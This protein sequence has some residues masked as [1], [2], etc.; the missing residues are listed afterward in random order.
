MFTYQ[1][2]LLI[3]SNLEDKDLDNFLS[4]DPSIQ[5]KVVKV[6]S[7]AREASAKTSAE[8]QNT[9]SEIKKIKKVR[10]R[11]IDKPT[12]KTCKSKKAGT[13]GYSVNVS[14]ETEEYLKVNSVVSPNDIVGYISATYEIPESRKLYGSVEN[15][16]RR[17]QKSGK[18]VKI[19]RG[20]F[21]WKKEETKPYYNMIKEFFEKN[22]G[23]AFS[24]QGL[25]S[26]L[27][28]EHYATLSQVDEE[29][30]TKAFKKIVDHLYD[31]NFLSKHTNFD[32]DIL[33]FV[34]GPATT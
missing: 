22:K 13:W 18:V 8:P 28:E 31:Q 12:F 26:I 7:S 10:S 2:S 29:T 4:L 25:V 24:I 3:A 16:I 34:V 1:E 23:T 5:K 11:S 32:G 14:N 19:S 21:S 27:T 17:L 33:Y 6:L 30:L 15:H 9:E 20:K